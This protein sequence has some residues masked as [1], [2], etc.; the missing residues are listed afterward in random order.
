VSNSNQ[1]AVGVG[2]KPSQCFCPEYDSSFAISHVRSLLSRR[3]SGQPCC[4]TGFV[5]GDD[6]ESAAVAAYYERIQS[7]FAAAER[8]CN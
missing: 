8:S 1:G 5:I 6:R 7:P 4:D 2:K 3:S